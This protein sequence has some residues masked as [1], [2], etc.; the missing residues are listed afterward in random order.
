MRVLAFTKYDREAASTRQRLLQFLPALSAAGI[1]V[2][3]R[4]LLDDAYVKC[5]ATGARAPKAAIIRNYARRVGQLRRA[6]DYDLVWVY[7]ELFPYLPALFEKLAYFS[8][9]PVI[10]DFDDAFFVPY[11]CHQQALVRQL[12]GGK[13]KH[14]IAGA[15]AATC[16]NAF[17]QAYAQPLCERTLIVPTVVDTAAYHPAIGATA[18]PVTIG[19]IGSPS[20]WANLQPLLPLLAS[21][22][23]EY[24]VR[25]RAVGAGV[26]AER[27]QFDGLELVTWSERTE[28]RDVQAMDIGIMPLLDL[29]FQRGKSGYKLIQY[30]ACGLPVVASPVGVNSEIVQPGI[31]LLASSQ[32]EWRAA[33]ERLIADPALRSSMGA[34][35]R[36][37]AV[38]AYSLA[39][40]APRLVELFQSV[41][42]RP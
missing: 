17:L 35:G 39:S 5:L 26:Q 24:N 10:Y 30:M 38:E 12:L 41:G 32:T 13:L 36:K 40:Q 27:D 11:D 28:I 34:A 7:A 14:L 2:D 8:R 20:T 37:R 22:C 16:G 31:G 9:R 25:V 19:W 15:A 29:P 18:G 3:Y 42:S 21:L 4:P 33:L 1:D 23:R 6:P